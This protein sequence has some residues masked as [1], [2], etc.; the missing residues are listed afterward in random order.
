M[1]LLR[2]DIRAQRECIEPFALLVL[3]STPQEQLQVARLH[4]QRHY[5]MAPQPL[6]AP[7]RAAGERLRIGYLS[8]DF[9]ATPPRS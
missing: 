6:H 5:P 7:A 9:G 8:A 2:E 3:P 4:A 1:A